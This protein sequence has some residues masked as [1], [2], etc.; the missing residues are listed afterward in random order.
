MTTGTRRDENAEPSERAKY[1]PLD[2]GDNSCL[3]ALNRSGMRTNG[4]CRCLADIR[5]PMRHVLAQRILASISAG[6]AA[7]AQESAKEIERL[8]KQRDALF[9]LMPASYVAAA[10]AALADG[11]KEE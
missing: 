10:R 4:G 5:Q 6:A 11:E 7:K 1:P 8:T 9:N 3:F 2:C